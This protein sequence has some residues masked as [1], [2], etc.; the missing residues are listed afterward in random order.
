M[1]KFT[2][3]VIVRLTKIESHLDRNTEVLNEHHKRSTQLEER[4][5]P[6][7]D[8]VEFLRKLGKFVI[9][10]AAFG[11]SVAGVISLFR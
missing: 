1:G 6:V 5:K 11:A 9:A 8:H 4:F 3:E 10:I 7:E 2:E